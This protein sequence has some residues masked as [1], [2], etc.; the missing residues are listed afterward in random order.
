[1]VWRFLCRGQGD[2]VCKNLFFSKLWS[3][4][5]PLLQFCPDDSEGCPSEAPPRLADGDF[6]AE[7]SWAHVSGFAEFF[8]LGPL[9]NSRLLRRMK[10]RRLFW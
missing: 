5:D 2:V 8:L 9:E 3:L 7:S 1:M 10:L 4:L 6:A